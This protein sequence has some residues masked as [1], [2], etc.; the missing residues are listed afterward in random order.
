MITGSQ[1]SVT[2]QACISSSGAALAALAMLYAVTAWLAV[3]F[4]R[5]PAQCGRGGKPPVTVL[6]PLCGAEHE[7]YGCLRSF[8]DQDYPCLQIV[9][10]GRD[11]DDPAL[12]VVR[13]MP[14]QF[15]A[16]RLPI[17]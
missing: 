12:A 6:K 9:V 17:G 7:L 10:G 4:R 11:A 13:R 1:L 8:C 2:A 15:P 16:V 5:A 14:L 3:R